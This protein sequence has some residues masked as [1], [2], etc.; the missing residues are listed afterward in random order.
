MG[1]LIDFQQFKE[2]REAGESTPPRTEGYCPFCQ[3]PTLIQRTSGDTE[4]HTYDTE[5][6]EA[7][8]KLK[9]LMATVVDYF[10]RQ[11]DGVQDDD[12]IAAFGEGMEEFLK[13]LEQ[14]QQV[15]E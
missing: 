7:Y 8:S 12:L 3:A 15:I 5:V 6:M 2:R 11:E 13:E 9:N 1:Q 4:I 14:E 10:K